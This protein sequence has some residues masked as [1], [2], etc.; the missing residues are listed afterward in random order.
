MNFVFAFF[1]CNLAKL[2]SSGYNTTKKVYAKIKKRLFCCRT[3]PKFSQLSLATTLLQDIISNLIILLRMN[4]LNKQTIIKFDLLTYCRARWAAEVRVC[5]LREALHH[6][7]QRQD[8][9]EHPP[10]EEPLLMQ[11]LQQGVLAQTRLGGMD[12]VN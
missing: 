7:L 3:R 6:Q 9:Q 5:G 4:C 1:S 10:R 11:V 12:Q 8:A 2:Y